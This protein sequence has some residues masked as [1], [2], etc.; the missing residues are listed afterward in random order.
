MRMLN[1]NRLG[2]LFICV[3][4]LAGCGEKA[5][6]SES[7]TP[8]ASEKRAVASAEGSEE[9]TVKDQV[10][11]ETVEAATVTLWFTYRAEEQQALESLVKAFNDKKGPITIDAV[12]VPYD[13][14]VDKLELTIPNGHG[15]DLF[16]FAHNMVGHWANLGLISPLSEF[17][18]PE[19]LQ[20]FL[21]NT[22]KALVYNKTLY[23]LPLAFKSLALYYNKA[24]V[25][26]PPK[27]VAELH[28]MAK[29]KEWS[30][31]LAFEAGL[32]YFHAPFL[33]G[34]DGALFD[35]KGTPNLN[36]DG[37]VSALSEV[38]K[39]LEDGVIATGLSSVTLSA[40]FN[41]GKAPVVMNGPWFR[42]EISEAIDYGVA[43]LP[44]LSNGKAMRPFLGSEGL[45]INANS[46]VKKQAFMVADFL[47]TDDSAKKRV[48]IGKQT[49]ANKAVYEDKVITSD[50]RY[51]IFLEQAKTATLM[52]SN[53]EMQKVWSHYDT[54]ILKVLSG[55]ASPKD[56]LNTAQTL[57]TKAVQAKE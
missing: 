53:P 29:E 8:V 23:G 57:V 7:A 6:P 46:K 35:D 54:A 33:F 30:P 40:L 19:L 44:S 15:P 21:P 22:V 49:I 43:T 26:T 13:A 48:E 3:A 10:A 24:I 31:S 42:G 52:P 47:T 41:E 1:L 56:A 17:A 14:F 11:K 36:N 4:C 39:L 38:K 2:S 20:R 37:A 51:G 55:S 28:A 12:P 5:A 25:N 32:L 34:H 45:F 18:K 16:I 27:T 50:P 9:K